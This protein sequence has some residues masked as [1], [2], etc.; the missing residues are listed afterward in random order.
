[1]NF[2]WKGMKGM[3][4]NFVRACHVCQTHKAE[5][6]KP[7]GLLSPLPIPRHVWTDIS[8]DFIEGLPTSK[9]KSAIF[10]VV[11]KLSKFAHFIPIS[12]PY[13]ATSIAQVFFDNV[14]KLY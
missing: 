12:H 5:L 11:Y 14:F 10:V 1:L 7:A 6:V 8:M 13:T 2:Y 4:R 3:V 9:G